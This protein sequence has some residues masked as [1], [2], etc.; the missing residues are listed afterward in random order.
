MMVELWQTEWCRA[1]RRIRQRR[2][3]CDIDAQPSLREKL[4]VDGEPYTIL[5]AWN[6]AA[7]DAERMP[8]IVGNDELA[9]VASAVREKLAAVVERAARYAETGRTNR[10]S[11]CAATV[12]RRSCST[13]RS[14]SSSAARNS[15][16]IFWTS[17]RNAA[18]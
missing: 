7:V 13:A 18:S 5:G 2:V 8:S 17:L 3:L 4:G 1:S 11:R 16:S 15:S 12:R 9:P 10:A 14:S 6:R